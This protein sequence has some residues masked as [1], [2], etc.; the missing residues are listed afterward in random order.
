M[1]HDRPCPVIL[2][3]I[4]YIALA[5]KNL[6]YLFAV[7]S[8]S[9]DSILLHLSTCLTQPELNFLAHHCAP[10][11]V[12]WTF[13]LVSN[14]HLRIKSCLICLFGQ[15]LL[16]QRLSHKRWRVRWQSLSQQALDNTLWNISALGYRN[17]RGRRRKITTGLCLVLSDSDQGFRSWPQIPLLTVPPHRNICILWQPLVTRLRDYF[18][19]RVFQVLCN[20]I[21]YV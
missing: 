1:N 12:L 19:F 14:F 20:K 15:S 17:S 8:L 7:Y 3:V 2:T 10:C 18:M 16:H 4:L 9:F 21:N 11:S 13:F 6:C 5:P